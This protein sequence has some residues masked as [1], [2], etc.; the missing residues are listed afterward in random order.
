[1]SNPEINNY[2]EDQK[3]ILELTR[4]VAS[5]TEAVIINFNALGK[6]L[7]ILEEHVNEPS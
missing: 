1:M 3:R 5:L 2:T 4:Q 7:A 6:R